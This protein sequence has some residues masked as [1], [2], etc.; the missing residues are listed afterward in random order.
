MS[1]PLRLG[2]LVV[3]VIAGIVLIARSLPLADLA[4]SVAADLRDRGWVG[5]VG[6]VVLYVCADVL[7]VPGALLTVAAGFTYGAWAGMAI[8]SPASVLAASIAFLLARSALRERIRRWLESTPHFE[9]VRA[10]IAENSLVV[11]LLLRLSPLVPFN[12]INYALGLTEITLGRYVAASFVGMLPGTWL[13]AYVGS[14]APTMVAGNTEVPGTA[15]IVG[16]AIGLMASIAAV[17]IVGR[18][19]QRRLAQQSLTPACEDAASDP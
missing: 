12:V 4:L 13:Y 10:S 19:A 5:V 7:M 3:A 18:A 15:R 14:L 16:L 6:F 1:K 11:I 2:F 8:S 17:Y 9:A